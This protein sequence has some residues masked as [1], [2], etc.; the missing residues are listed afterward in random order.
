MSLLLRPHDFV[1]VTQFLALDF[2]LS[3]D[4]SQHIPSEIRNV[5]AMHPSVVEH[6]KAHSSCPVVGPAGLTSFPL[7]MKTPVS[8]MHAVKKL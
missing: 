8:I 5:Q 3:S 4:L 6:R 7:P 2:I 1:P